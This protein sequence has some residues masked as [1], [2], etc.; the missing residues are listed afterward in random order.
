[1]PRITEASQFTQGIRD[2]EDEDI[3]NA[4]AASLDTPQLTATYVHSAD[5]TPATEA[6]RRTRAR[7]IEALSAA[8]VYKDS[9]GLCKAMRESLEAAGLEQPGFITKTTTTSI[10]QNKRAETSRTSE[11]PLPQTS[12]PPKV[13]MTG[14]AQS[15]EEL[16]DPSKAPATIQDII[17]DM[18]LELALRLHPVN[19]PDG[20]TYVYIDPPSKQPEQDYDSYNVYRSRFE[21]PMIMKSSTLYSLNS[22]VLKKAL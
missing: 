13:R 9:P 10:D 4:I 17:R 16:S 11:P 15:S 7:Q 22:A 12:G 20:D 1:M 3:A 18:D 14:K 19:E 6:Q 21:I 2:V 5:W 8:A